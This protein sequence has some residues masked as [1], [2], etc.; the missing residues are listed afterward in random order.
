MKNTSWKNKTQ[1]YNKHVKRKAEWS[2]QEPSIIEKIPK[3]KFVEIWPVQ[4]HNDNPIN[5]QLDNTG[6][7]LVVLQLTSPLNPVAYPISEAN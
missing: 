2:S 7:V 4:F 1:K 5:Y 6:N 3:Q